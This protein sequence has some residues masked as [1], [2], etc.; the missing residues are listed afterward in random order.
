MRVLYD[1]LT[2]DTSIFV[3]SSITCAN[4]M[5]VSYIPIAKA[6]GFTTLLIIY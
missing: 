3:P 2:F 6:R 1:D 4:L 5:E